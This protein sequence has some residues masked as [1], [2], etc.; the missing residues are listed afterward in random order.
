LR[1][2]TPCPKVHLHEGRGQALWSFHYWRDERQSSGMVKTT[3]QV[4]RI[5]PAKG[6][7]AL[8]KKQAEAERDRFLEA[9]AGTCHPKEPLV[10]PPNAGDILF[11]TLAEIWEW[12]YVER[13]VGGKSLIAVSTK[14][15]YLN[16]LHNHILP[17]GRQHPSA[18]FALK[19]VL[20]WLQTESGS[21]FMMVDLRNIMS[22]I[23]TK[24]QE[25][26]I[27]PDIFA[28][29]IAR[30]KLPKKWQ[31][32]ERRILSEQETVRVL[33]HLEDPHRL[34]SEIL[35]CHRH[36]HFRSHGIA[37]QARPSRQGIHSNRAAS[38]ARRHRRSEVRTQQADAHPRWFGRKSSSLDRIARRLITG[39]LGVSAAKS[40]KA[41]VGF[42]CSRRFEG[43]SQEREL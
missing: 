40:F 38:L 8:T 32:Y 20:D 25:W 27:L 14:G 30:V 6:K 42:R 24:A 31:V 2:R 4:C 29:P 34:V 22:G 11:G 9:L 28:N 17:S 10:L 7:N 18:S 39:W 43:G 1:L 13:V 5:G 37:G 23:F 35:S 16:H 19:V 15:K 26:E 41:D 21:W 3:R 12:D 36:T 33:G